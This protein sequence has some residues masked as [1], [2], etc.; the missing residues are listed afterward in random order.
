[1]TTKTTIT[2]LQREVSELLGELLDNPEAQAEFFDK[3]GWTPEEYYHETMKDILQYLEDNPHAQLEL[4]F[5]TVNKKI[6]DKNREELERK[7]A[8]AKAEQNLLEQEEEDKWDNRPW[9]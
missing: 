8:I 6:A 2:E 9:D 1:M 7:N 4:E 5:E 3:H